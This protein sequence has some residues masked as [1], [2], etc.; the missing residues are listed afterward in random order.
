MSPATHPPCNAANSCALIEDEIARSCALFDGDGPPMKGCRTDPKG[1]E[2]AADV[3]RRYY[4]ALDARDYSTAWTQW[5]DDGQ[6]GQT[7]KAFENGYAHTRSTRV[8]IGALT[9]GDGG[10]GSIYQPV[11]VTVDATLDDGRHQRFVGSYVVRRVNDVDGASPS[12]LRWHIDSAR[13]TPV[14]LSAG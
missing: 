1:M 3:V 10:A 4:S 12:Q 13:L 11:P 9:P 2:A 14:R 7:F 8:T 6:P 5:G